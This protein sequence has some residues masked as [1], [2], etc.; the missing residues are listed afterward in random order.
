MRQLRAD[1]ARQHVAIVAETEFC[2]LAQHRLIDCFG[3]AKNLLGEA[4]Q[5]GDELGR[6]EHLGAFRGLYLV[7]FVV[8]LCVLEREGAMGCIYRDSRKERPQ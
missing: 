1:D 8:E 2:V 5:L 6:N 4:L 3:G 7:N